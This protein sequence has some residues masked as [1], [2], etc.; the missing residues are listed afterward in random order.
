MRHV[1]EAQKEIQRE[2][3]KEIEAVHTGMAELKEMMRLLLE[4][5]Q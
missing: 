4:Q 1:E 5:K 2:M 3:R